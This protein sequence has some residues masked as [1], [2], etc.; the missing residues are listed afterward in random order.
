MLNVALTQVFRLFS[1]CL[2]EAPLAAAAASSLL[3]FNAMSFV[4]QDL[5][6]FWHSCLQIISGRMSTAMIDVW[7]EL[8][9]WV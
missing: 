2:V 1:K 9:E 3:E 7:A 8:C 6:K 5:E 4:H